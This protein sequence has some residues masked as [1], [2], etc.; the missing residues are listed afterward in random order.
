MS[1]YV[2]AGLLIGALLSN[3][4]FSQEHSAEYDEIRSDIAALSARLQKL[5]EENAALK[6]QN[7]ELVQTIEMQTPPAAPATAQSAP[8]AEVKPAVLPWYENIMIGGLVF[9]DAYALVDNHSPGVDDQTGFWIRRAYLT[10]DSKITDA[11]SSRFRFE[12]NSPGNFTTNG[13]LDPYVKDAYLARTANG[14]TLYLGMS[15]SPT[16][17]FVET[18]WSYRHIEKTPVDLYRMG[19]SRDIGVAYKGSADEGRIFYHAMLGNG[20]GTGS[21]TNDGKK[22]M[23]SVGYNLTPSLTAQF[24]ADYEDR[25]NHTNRNTYQGFL[26]WK[27]EQSRYGLSYTWQNREQQDAPEAPVSVASIFGAWNL[28]DKSTLVARYD[29]NF[30]GYPDANQV[31]Y[32]VFPNNTEFNFAILGWNYQFNP[33]ISFGPNLEY[34]M[35]RE[36][37]GVPAPDNDLMF[38]A[39]LFYQF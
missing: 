17:D 7:A 23:L 24:Y 4:A 29:Y 20:A 35:Y 25:P 5:E 37:D 9:G 6:Q 26:G 16:F 10:F 36:T 39:T 15:P 34:T 33:Q 18:F 31:P 11:W 14:S 30:D 13:P 2:F 21:E 12:V 22:A 32:L 38:R 19:S 3:P 28:T 1:R 27:A 8:A